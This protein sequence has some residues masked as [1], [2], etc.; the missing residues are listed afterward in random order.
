MGYVHIYCGDGKGKTSAAL[1]LSVRAA[2][3]GK[4]VLIVRFLKNE[5]SGEVTA[6]RKIPGIT[7]EPCDREFGFVFRMN[8]EQKT[9]AA[10]Y[11]QARFESACR[12]AAE[13]N[14]DVL[15][16]DEILAACSY[17]MV[18]EKD[19]VSFLDGRSKDL[20]IVLTG[21]NPSDS[22]A[23]RADYL[24]EIRMKKHPFEKGIPARKGIEY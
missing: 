7:V 19:V 6:L 16:L 12:K 22:L 21:R 13:E 2:G 10:R 17:K 5:D 9:E 14:Y 15:V 4:K 20:E 24:S 18:R 11:Y 1:G 8:E 3:R 23:E